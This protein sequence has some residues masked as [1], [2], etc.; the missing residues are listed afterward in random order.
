MGLLK[1]YKNSYIKHI[2]RTPFHFFAW[3]LGFYK[4][5]EP[6]ETV[7]EDFTYPF[8]EKKEDKTNRAVFI[9]HCTYLVSVE[10]TNFLTDP[11][12]SKRCSPFSFF[13]PKRRSEPGIQISE[14][15]KVDYVLISHNHYDHLDLS[16]IKELIS[17]HPNVLI[18]VPT[19]LKKWFRKN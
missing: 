12:W 19:G 16:S 15:E 4:D 9:N 11:I 17:Y 2:K 1:R 3:M 18:I 8:P 13:G 14:L 6:L 10:G 7:P 5:K